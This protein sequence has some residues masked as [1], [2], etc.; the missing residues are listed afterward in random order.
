MS[1]LP[2]HFRKANILIVDDN[3]T[4][5]VLLERI[6]E[7]AGYE[8]VTGESDS[9]KVK[10]LYEKNR[11]DLILLD[12]RM[13]HMTGHDV[14]DAL[15]KVAGTDYLPILVLTAETDQE[16]KLKALSGGA[17]DFL[18]KPFDRLEALN[19][20]QNMLE[21]R[22]LHKELR[23]QNDILEEKVRERTQQLNDTRMEIIRRLG[24]AAEFRDNET[25]MH[26]IRM[27]HACAR[28]G[29]AFGLSDGECERILCASPMHDVGKI[30]I[31]DRILLKPGPLDPDEWEI[32]KGH[33]QIGADLLSG[34]KSELLE[35]ASTIALTHHEKWDGS[36][37]PNGIA[38]EDIPLVGRITA[39]C[40][41]FDALTSVRP[42]KDAW[43]V[44]K[45]VEEISS[46]RGRHFDPNL[47]DMFLNILPEI[48]DINARFTD[49]PGVERNLA[50]LH[51]LHAS[52]D[53]L[54]LVR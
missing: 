20:I 37:Y 40:D 46:Q 52:G 21:V 17:K 44:E 31:P 22:L 1:T 33:S 5:V 26:V 34:H 12:I 9:R 35:M 45:A 10:S 28:L 42:Y 2:E 8:D 14:M 48:L 19:R 30:G 16:T 54:K 18:H 13:P 43:P 53:G 7:S 24:R 41:V 11:Y 49:E 32:M 50:D 36:G 29:S 39:I 47:T 38:G 15:R 27:S 3:P 25:G 6:L 4:N 23:S 51:P